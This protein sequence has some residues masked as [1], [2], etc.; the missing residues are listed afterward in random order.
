MR[1]VRF[2]VVNALGGIRD[3]TAENALEAALD[4]V[5]PHVRYLARRLRTGTA[6]AV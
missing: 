4:D 3:A 1:L 5:H 6:N 2:A